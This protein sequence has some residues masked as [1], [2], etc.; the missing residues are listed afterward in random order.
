MS[1][2]KITQNHLLTTI[3]GPLSADDA[4][5]HFSRRSDLTYRRI[6]HVTVSDVDMYMSLLTGS[7]LRDCTFSRISFARSDLDGVRAEKSTFVECDFTNCDIRSSVFADCKF[8]ACTFTGAFIDDCQFQGSDLAD[9]N[10]ERATLTNCNFFKSTLRGCQ[11]PQASFLHSKL[12]D[13][14]VT[15]V[16]LG[17]CTILYV[18]LRDS[19][20]TGISISAECIGGIFGITREQ[21]HQARIYYLGEHESVPP[22]A[23]LPEAIHEQYL[24]RKWY[25]GQLVFNLNFN[26]AST[27]EAFNTYLSLS[28]ER[29]SEFGFVKGDELE[30]L[31]D[32]L[33]EL[34]FLERLPLFTALNVLEWC[35]ALEATIKEV[36]KD[37]PESSSDPFRVFISRV[38]LL[39]NSLLD[40]LD[41]E[42]PQIPISESDKRMCVKAIFDQKPM[43]SLAELLNSIPIPP[44]LGG[45]IRARLIRTEQGSYV[46]VVLTTLFS[47]VCLQVFL[48]LINGC[49]IQLTELKERVKLL[50]RKKAPKTYVELALSTTQHG[51]PLILAALPRLIAHVKGL[52]WLKGASLGG[53]LPSNFLSVQEV[54]CDDEASSSAEGVPPAQEN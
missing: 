2:D 7:L 3:L 44:T 32:L 38:V 43:L 26:L 29:F 16:N 54:A 24:Q 46:E 27:L 23:D 8:E 12:Y 47:M 14:T 13:C 52:P 1:S 51:S 9:C 48:F 15:D 30:F 10:L 18:I 37:L 22:D 41:Q 50:A 33:E 45:N 39:T 5:R 20:L 25:I 36:N 17:D 35:T 11:I 28:H 21:L 34:A 42:L 4:A 49:V 40:R 19:R 53:F 6:E 31:G